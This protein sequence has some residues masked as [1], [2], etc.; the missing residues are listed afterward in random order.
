MVLRVSEFKFPKAVLDPAAECVGCSPLKYEMGFLREDSKWG[1][2][3]NK[4][5]E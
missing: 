4:L 3:D 2:D 5:T 1:Q